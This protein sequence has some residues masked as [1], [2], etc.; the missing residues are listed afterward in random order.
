MDSRMPKWDSLGAVGML[1]RIAEVC[2]KELESRKD[3]EHLLDY[4]D[5]LRDLFGCDRL[6]SCYVD[7]DTG[8]ALPADADDRGP[9]WWEGFDEPNAD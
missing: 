6:L 9:E 7:F 4:V 5:A 3:S 1:E 8:A 2:G